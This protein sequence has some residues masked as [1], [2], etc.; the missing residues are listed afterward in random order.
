MSNRIAVEKNTYSKKK[1]PYQ[2]DIARIV[3]VVNA[4]TK[5]VSYTNKYIK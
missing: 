5:R 4:V 3:V 2:N 1:V